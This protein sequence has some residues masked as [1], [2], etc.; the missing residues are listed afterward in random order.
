MTM[1]VEPT[2][3]GC[4]AWSDTSIASK[5]ILRNLQAKGV[6]I[7]TGLHL[8][9]ARRCACLLV[10]GFQSARYRQVILEFDRDALICE[11]LEN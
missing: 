3:W 2:M 1:N 8:L 10:D 4:V 9:E 11:R 5:R 6:I 7:E